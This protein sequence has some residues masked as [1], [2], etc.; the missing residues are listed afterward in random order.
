MAALSRRL[1]AP[2]VTAFVRTVLGRTC[3]HR[4]FYNWG[5]SS[6]A[7]R[8]AGSSGSGWNTADEFATASSVEEDGFEPLGPGTTK[9]CDRRNHPILDPPR[10][11]QRN[12]DPE[13]GFWIGWVN[14]MVRPR[15]GQT[16]APPRAYAGPMLGIPRAGGRLSG[17][18]RCSGRRSSGKPGGCYGFFAG[19]LSKRAI[20]EPDLAGLCRGES[21]VCLAQERFSGPGTPSVGSSEGE[22]A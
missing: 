12:G 22:P 7:P 17:I 2:G 16:I 11:K 15:S 5:R 13:A 20:S 14:G 6:A 19:P 3:R 1:T 21:A 18:R 9:L 10:F 8:A 4:H